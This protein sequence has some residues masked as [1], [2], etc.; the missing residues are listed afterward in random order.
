MIATIRFLIRLPLYVLLAPIILFAFSI[1][2]CVSVFEW[3]FEGGSLRE[4]IETNL[5]L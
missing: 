1:I 5:E 4:T 3:A 2:V